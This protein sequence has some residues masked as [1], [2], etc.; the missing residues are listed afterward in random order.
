MFL[1]CINI[2]GFRGINQ[3]TLNLEK[4]GGVLIGENTWGKSSL[5]NA[6]MLLSPQNSSYSFVSSDFYQDSSHRQV[7]QQIAVSFTFT[8]YQDLATHDTLFQN[9]A[10]KRQSDQRR[11]IIYQITA[12]QDGEKIVTERHFINELK[13]VINIANEQAIIDKFIQHFPVIRLKNPLESNKTT[14]ASEP[15]SQHY[16]DQLSQQLVDHSQPIDSE[17]LY[18]GLQAARVLLEYY[19]TDQQKRHSL[20]R[21]SKQTKPTLEDWDSL[22][23]MTQILNKLD[24]DYIRVTLLGVFAALLNA[25]ND[26]HLTPDSVPILLLEEPES[27]LHPI[28]LSVGMNLLNNLPVQKI[29][30]T[31]SSDLIALTELERIYRLVRFPDHIEAYHIAPRGLSISDSRRIMFHILYRRASALFARCWLLVEGETEVWMLSELASQCGY[32]LNSEGIQVI[33][34]AQ[35]GL[36]PLI[37]FADKMGIRWYVLSDG[38]MAGKKYSATVRSLCPDDKD[39]DEYL[40]VLPANDI[41]NFMFRHGFSHIYKM[42]AYG[43]TEHIDVPVSRIIQKAINKTSKPDLAIA[44]CDEVKKRGPDAIPHLLKQMFSRVVGVAKNSD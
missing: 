29:I 34:F 35:C 1:E 39:V 9:I 41:E 7:K 36:R 10:F 6:L 5:L 22:E 4:E 23:R 8:S 21:T 17:K 38:D 3:L 14:D 40:T 26:N 33:E 43:T 12:V 30:T 2:I 16:I 13:Q 20:N 24:D 11:C 18:K 42:L 15:L 25:S 44:V 27:Q 32:H 28:I 37:K 31:N 19:L